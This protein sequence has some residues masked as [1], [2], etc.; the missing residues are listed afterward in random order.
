MTYAIPFIAKA[1]N[2]QRETMWNKFAYLFVSEFKYRLSQVRA[3]CPIVY[4]S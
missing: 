3:P 1:H 2:L 4:Y